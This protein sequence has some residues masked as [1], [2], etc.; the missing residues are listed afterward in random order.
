MRQ[1]SYFG[2]LCGDV[3]LLKSG[4]EREGNEEKLIEMLQMFEGR[5]QMTERVFQ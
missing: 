5:G 2:E 4:P 3:R 1:R